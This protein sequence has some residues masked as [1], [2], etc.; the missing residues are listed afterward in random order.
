MIITQ[1][2]RYSLR[3]LLR[4]PSFTAIAIGVIA[5]AV[6][7]NTAIFSVVNGILLKPLPYHDPD[8]LF[9]VFL[10]N[11]KQKLFDMPVSAADFLDW[12]ANNHIF[13]KTAI[14]SNT[15]FNVTGDGYPEQVAGA[16]VSADFFA[17]LGV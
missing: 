14:Y 11:E 10:T 2:L 12:R 1:D 8:K 13:E 16:V 15:G 3:T 17:T 6:G 5:I 7:A 4:K 9:R